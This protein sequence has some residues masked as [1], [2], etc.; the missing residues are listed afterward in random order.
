MQIVLFVRFMFFF[1]ECVKILMLSIVFFYYI[2]SC[3]TRQMKI[4]SDFDS[5]DRA[6]RQSN[7]DKVS[8]LG[9][10]RGSLAGSPSAKWSAGLVEGQDPV[11]FESV[12]QVRIEN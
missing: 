7:I 2:F 4:K 12:R 3:A 8:E 6:I 10:L 9:G 11:P 5:A 1:D